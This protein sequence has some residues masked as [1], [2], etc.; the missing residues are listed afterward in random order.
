MKSEKAKFRMSV[1]IQRSSTNDKISVITKVHYF[2]GSGPVCFVPF[3]LEP[4]DIVEVNNR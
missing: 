2:S 3:Y 1:A 4:F